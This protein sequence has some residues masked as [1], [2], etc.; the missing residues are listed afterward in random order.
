MFFYPCQSRKLFIVVYKGAKSFLNHLCSFPLLQFYGSAFRFSINKERFVED[1][2]AAY[3][4]RPRTQ[5][6]KETP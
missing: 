3:F 5:R 6:W 1:T 2:K 4:A